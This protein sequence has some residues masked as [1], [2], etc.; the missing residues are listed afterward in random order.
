MRSQYA[1]LEYVGLHVC[2][3]CTVSSSPRTASTAVRLSSL[4]LG[5]SC[6][7][8]WTVRTATPA[9]SASSA[10]VR[11]NCLRLLRTCW[12][13]VG[14][15]DIICMILHIAPRTALQRTES[16]SIMHD[17]ADSHATCGHTQAAPLILQ[18]RAGRK[19]GSDPGRLAA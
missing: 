2:L 15:T 11:R 18:Y 1:L 7:I 3:S 16:K 9:R 6:S 4:R 13:I 8:S 17:A 14:G 12:P 5:L 10:W 19:Q